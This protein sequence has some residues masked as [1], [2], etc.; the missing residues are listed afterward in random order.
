MV[1]EGIPWARHQPAVV[2]AAAGTQIQCARSRLT[3]ET[4]PSQSAER[5]EKAA[6][7][8]WTVLLFA[9]QPAGRLAVQETAT[10]LAVLAVLAVLAAELPH[11]RV[12][13]L[14]NLA[15]M[16]RMVDRLKAEQAAAG[17]ARPH[18]SSAK[19]QARCILA[20]VEEALHRKRQT[21]APAQMAAVVTAAIRGLLRLLAALTPAAALEVVNLTRMEYPVLLAAPVSAA[22]A[23]Q[24]RQLDDIREDQGRHGDQRAVHPA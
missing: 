24:G 5:V 17:K 1:A 20:E 13:R 4:T 22:C 7:S 10:A 11:T 12:T 18:A 21:A 23:I 15:Q 19:V 6:L 3:R 8:K 14:A 16:A 9:R 2:A